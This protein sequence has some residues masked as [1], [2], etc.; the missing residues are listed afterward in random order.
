M[1]MFGMLGQRLFQWVDASPY[2]A[3]YHELYE[4]DE[5]DKVTT[6]LVNSLERWF[7]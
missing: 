6:F 2:A 3:Q 1:G 5:I 4:I 7:V